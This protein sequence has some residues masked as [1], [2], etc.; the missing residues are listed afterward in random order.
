VVASTGA[1]PQQQT[2][3]NIARA[4]AVSRRVVD[5]GGAIVICSDISSPP[6]PALQGLADASDIESARRQLRS[7]SAEDT[8][9]ALQLIEALEHGSVYLVSRLDEDTVQRLGMAPVERPEEI[10]HLIRQHKTCI[11]LN[12]AQHVIPA[13]RTCKT[14]S[15][16]TQP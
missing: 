6:G 12:N 4:L 11:L 3:Q 8:W 1:D 13:A 14:S 5:A 9:P 16:H 15:P 2:W 7:Q 10:G